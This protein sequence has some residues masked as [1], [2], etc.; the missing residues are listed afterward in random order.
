MH[1]PSFKRQWTVDDLQDLPD[2]GNRYEVIDGALFVT[3]APSWKHQEAAAEI[4]AIL[5]SYLR[6][7][8]VGH[9]YIA[10][11][12]VI[13][14]SKTAVQP[15][16]FVVPLVDGRRPESFE[17]VG[18]LLVTIE[19]LSPNTA[20]ADRVAKRT[21]FREEGVAEYWIVDLD[22]RTI[23]RSTPD[24]PRPEIGVERL[25]WTPDGAAESLV[26]DLPGYFATVLDG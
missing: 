25:E 21:L 2:D 8:R 5:R 4:Y 20:R 1:M 9:A 16:V 10:P 3:P 17:E 22:S 14:S 12:D 6:R 19:V 24:E 26:I 18:R 23:E 7:E 15:D 11:A 13:F